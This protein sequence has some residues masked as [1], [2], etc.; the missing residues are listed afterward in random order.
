M[1]ARI[2][3]VLKVT[4][5]QVDHLISK[6]RGEAVGLRLGPDHEQGLALAGLYL[7][8]L[9]SF[10]QLPAAQVR[11]RQSMDQQGSTTR[12]VAQ[13]QDRRHPVRLT[14]NFKTNCGTRLAFCQMVLL[15]LG[16]RVLNRL[17]HNRSEVLRTAI[18][19]W[20]AGQFMKQHPRGL[21]ARLDHGPGER[22][23]MIPPFQNLGQ[24]LGGLEAHDRVELVAAALTERVDELVGFRTEELDPVGNI[25]ASLVKQ[26]TS[27][28]NGGDFR[29]P[30]F[31]RLKN[32]KGAAGTESGREADGLVLQ[33]RLKL[34]E[35]G[36][37]LMRPKEGSDQPHPV[38]IAR[39]KEQLAKVNPSHRA[40]ANRKRSIPA[41]SRS[42]R[43]PR[44][45][46]F[47]SSSSG[48]TLSL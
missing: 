12:I 40:G 43:S 4:L 7:G 22:L 41:T 35:P 2:R 3:I 14:E 38:R 47:L 39:L 25:A 20:K 45:S 34:G 46:C 23:A 19:G 15:G 33:R 29:L 31:L 6:A 27:Q 30:Q 44:E 9:Q 36:I 42:C 5:G 28:H 11:R 10:D 37:F 26:R 17:L 32:G 8:I 24:R 13:L 1:Y 48:I 18:W 21:R 16:Q